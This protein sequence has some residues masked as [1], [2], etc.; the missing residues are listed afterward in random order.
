[1]QQGARRILIQL[2]TGGGKTVLIA[3]MLATAAVRRRRAWFCVH[4]KELLDQSAQTFI[5]AADIHTG[6]V[7]A[8]YPSSPLAPVQV[9]SVQSLQKRASKLR[10]PDLVVFDE[11]HH[12]ASKSWADVAALFP[13]AIQIGLSATPQRLDGQGLSAHFDVMVQGPTTAWL[14]AQGF[15]SPYR[16]FAPS[17]SLSMAGVHHV[18]GDFNR[19]EVAAKMDNSTVVGDALS[20]YQQ[21]GGAGRALV[22]AWS[23]DA[24]RAIAQQFNDA[25]VPAQHVDGETP[26]PERAAAM[27]RFRA[28]D[29]R[30]LTN[31]ELFGEGLDVPAVDSIFLLR[32]T[33]SLG[34]YLQQVGRGLRAAPGKTSVTIFDHVN[35]WQRHGL[36]DDERTWTLEG[37]KRGP[38][39]SLALSKRCMKCFGVCRLSVVACP[40]CGNVFDVQSRQVAQV[41]GTLQEADL[42]ALRLFGFSG[43]ATTTQPKTATQ[44]LE[45]FQALAKAKGYKSGW[46]WRQFVFHQQRQRRRA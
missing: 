13:D 6:I 1:M 26:K 5:E 20:H 30:V 8:G 22:F 38:R 11:C 18:G 28:G 14:I 23:L 45:D 44:T 42:G 27:R 37:K 41:A 15:L 34:L 9:C 43:G 24:S 25:G 46:A 33:D 3:Q 16:L 10:P 40:Y 2:P 19:K 31:V 12:L 39:D 29:L 4:R 21:H 36:P 7:A 17:A 35:N 32:P